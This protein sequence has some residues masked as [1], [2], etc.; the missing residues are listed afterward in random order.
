MKRS[1]MLFLLVASIVFA[2]LLPG[3]IPKDKEPPGY[4]PWDT[5]VHG[6]VSF[7]QLDW[8]EL[9]GQS[10]YPYS[11]VG[12]AEFVFLDGAEDWFLEDNGGGWIN[13]LI[14]TTADTED[15]LWAVR[16]LYLSFADS[17]YLESASPRVQFSLGLDGETPIQ[18][19]EAAVFL[20]SEPLDTQPEAETLS[21]Y[22][23]YPSQYLVGGRDGGSSGIASIHIIIGPWI[24]PF[25]PVVRT[26]FIGITPDQIAEIDEGHSGCA[27]GSVARSI[28]YLSKQH[29]F[30]TDSPQDMYSNLVEFMGTDIC[31]A[32]T[33]DEN[34]LSGKNLY[35]ETVE[36]SISSEVVY[37]DSYDPDEGLGWA[38]LIERVQDAL[39]NNCDVEVLIGWN[40][41]GGHAAMVSSVTV[42]ADGST[43]ITYVDDPNQGDN[44]AENAHHVISTNSSGAFGTGTVDGFM[45][46]CY[47]DD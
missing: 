2:I 6:E 10:K 7:S 4:E 41:G 30:D 39:D 45:I 31:G 11:N 1:L 32:G 29:D 44:K 8:L 15:L 47:D 46:E 40:G 42:H 33:T 27:P 34:M 36:L 20:S 17:A 14:S 26:A 37:S 23:V 5:D 3:C 28:S 38:A 35:T 43:T 13:V 21:Q 9:P 18:S 12:Q 19:L 24:G 25:S 16:N 22:S